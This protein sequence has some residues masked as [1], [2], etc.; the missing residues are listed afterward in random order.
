[1]AGQVAVVT[2]GGQ[3]IGRAIALRLARDGMDVVVADM[4]ADA[5]EAVAAE[6]RAAGRR[7]LAVAA[8]VTDAAGRER[9]LDAAVSGLGRLDALV[10]NAGAMRVA[11]PLDVTEEHWDVLMAVNAKAVYFCCQLALRRMVA[12]RSGRVVNIAS[13]AGKLA[14]T[15][16][17]PIYNVSKAAVI[18]MTK[19]LALAHA[20]DGVR[21]NAVCPGIVDTPMQVVVDREFARVSGRSPEQ[22]R[23][24]RLARIPMGRVE[25]PEDVAA[26]VSFL[27]GPDSHYI[28]GEA[29]PV[30]GGILTGW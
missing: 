21:V 27:V 11:L 3:G 24:E 20:A 15:A 12:Q 8:D 29:V 28:T 26:V 2:G 17:H 14:S 13:I 16:Q 10:N 7:A 4:R 1:V 5:A 23:A 22:I 19:T 25:Q 18:A 9:M 6:V 30:T